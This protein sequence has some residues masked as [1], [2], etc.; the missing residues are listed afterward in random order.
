MKLRS[1]RIC[2]DM[3]HNLIIFRDVADKIFKLFTMGETLMSSHENADRVKKLMG[4]INIAYDTF[5][6]LCPQSDNLDLPGNVSSK[7]D[8]DTKYWVFKQTVQQWFDSLAAEDLKV[9]NTQGKMS[10]GGDDPS[11]I[12]SFLPSTSKRLPNELDKNFSRCHISETAASVKSESRQAPSEISDNSQFTT[13]SRSSK[14]SSSSSASRLKRAKVKLELAL[15]AQRQNEERL[16]EKDELVRLERNRKLAEDKRKVEA[17]R[18]ETQ[19]Y[20]MENNCD[21]NLIKQ[22]SKFSLGSLHEPRLIATAGP[23]TSLRN[24]TYSKE[25]WFHDLGKVQKEKHKLELHKPTEGNPGEFE[26]LYTGNSSR[27]AFTST[28]QGFPPKSEINNID[29]LKE[30]SEQL[31]PK[32]SIKKFEGDPMDYWAFFNRFTCHVA[33]WLPPKRKMSYLLQH[34]SEEVCRFIRHFEDIHDGRFAYDM[35]WQELERRYG[36]SHLIVQA[37]EERLLSIPRIDREVAERLNSLSIL[38]RRSCYALAD[39]SAASN[40]NSVQFLTAIVNKFPV[41]LK[42]RWIEYSANIAEE[43]GSLASFKDLDK[44]VEHQAK[45]ANSVFGLKLF[46]IKVETSFSKIKTTSLSSAT[47]SSFVSKQS[48]SVKCVCCLENHLVYRCPEFR[49]FS[50]NEK[51]Q[52]VKKY[53]LC[54]L[55]LNP[56]HLGSSCTFGINCK[57]KGCG[58]VLHNTLLHPS[59]NFVSRPTKNIINDSETLDSEGKTNAG[60]IEIKSVTTSTL[61]VKSITSHAYLD[62]VPVKVVKDSNVVYTYALLDTGSDRSFCEQR[63]A[64]ALKLRQDKQFRLSI[65][66][67][68]SVNPTYVE[69]SSVSLDICSLNNENKMELSTVVVVDS[70]PVAPTISPK[71]QTLLNYP[72]LRDISFPILENASVILL[73]GN[74]NAKAH[75]CLESRFS[76]AP[77]ESPDAIL[78]PFGWT[79]RGT[80]LDNDV[81]CRVQSSNFFV[82]GHEWPTERKEIEKLIVTDEGEVFFDKISELVDKEDLINVLLHHKAILE[83]SCM[84]SLEDSIAYDIMTRQLQYVDGHYQLRLLWKNDMTVLPESSAMA[85]RRLQCLK[86]RFLK[87]PDIHQLY[88]KSNEEYY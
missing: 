64:D 69:S 2:S 47:G 53:N 46:P 67:M 20:E 68:T 14:S 70:I 21:N 18:F 4:E 6:T 11:S 42:R 22:D 3:E 49:R 74:D 76:P 61:A 27:S 81:T 10:Q 66:T 32:P 58:S 36:Q 9:S 56:G 38:M 45:L 48:K 15:L 5:N 77:D 35:A 25:V 28:S 60:S 44:F 43:K 13:K 41:E 83:F 1:G 17:A 55:C 88:N 85:L 29:F 57:K 52:F 50:I 79:L 87:N 59:D 16:R 80:R 54:R 26:N 73:I 75:R 8:F 62:I 72:H 30:T 39:R 34:C 7:L 40:L 51:W 84:Y 23:S 12:P 33:N 37:C 31:L 86:K 78:T 63:L 71:N 82:C 19:L 65:Q 24:K